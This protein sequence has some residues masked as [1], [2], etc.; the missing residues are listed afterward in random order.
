LNQGGCREGTGGLPSPKPLGL[1]ARRKG[2]PKAPSRGPPLIE[3]KMEVIDEKKGN[4]RGSR[5]SERGNKRC[6]IN[7]HEKKKFIA[8]SERDER[9]AFRR[10]GAG[11]NG[12]DFPTG[13]LRYP[14]EGGSRKIRRCVR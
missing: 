10:W 8:R 2:P 5:N 14:E 9:K 3:S 7:L 6:S 13:D 4:F 12:K 1:G 11:K